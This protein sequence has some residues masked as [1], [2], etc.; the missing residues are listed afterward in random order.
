M[1]RF[2]H[3]GTRQDDW[4]TDMLDTS[5][6]SGAQSFSIHDGRVHFIGPG[7]GKNRAFASIEIRII[8]HHPDRGFDR[9]ETRSPAVENFTTRAERV[10]NSRTIFSLALGSHFAPLDGAGATMHRQCDSMGVLFQDRKSV[11]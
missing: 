4:I 6:R 9:V 8:L 1:L 10:L 11:V 2:F 3:D 5:H 7:T